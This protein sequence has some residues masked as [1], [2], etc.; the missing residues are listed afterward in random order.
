M[1]KNGIINQYLDY[2]HDPNLEN[3]THI[4]IV[5][6]HIVESNVTDYFKFIYFN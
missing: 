4:K 6:K 5:L 1:D 2:L 3:M